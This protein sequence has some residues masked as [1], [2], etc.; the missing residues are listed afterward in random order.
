MTSLR[1]R[2]EPSAGSASLAGLG[3]GVV[4][5]GCCVGPAVAV[6][7]G[8]TSAT[9]AIDVARNLYAEWGWAFKLAGTGF[10]AAAIGVA[11]KRSLRC[12]TKPRLLRFTAILVTTASVSYGFLYIATTSLG[13]RASASTIAPI[14]VR[15]STVEA[16]LASAVMQVRR[17][18][19]DVTID[20][21]GASS[22]T[23]RFR[24]AFQIPDV[25]PSS[26]EYNEE[27]SRRIGDS[28]EATLLLLQTIATQ[29]PSIVQ[30]SASDDLMWVPTWSREQVLDSHDPH[31]YRDFDTYTRF[32]MSADALSG[33]SQLQTDRSL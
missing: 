17:R 15:G 27:V 31:E 12:S 33:Y 20:I 28:R 13:D 19:R 32:V 18:Y 9:V 10:A 3:A 16:E 14:T 11:R 29:V 22:S 6:L 26:E 7:F 24:I 30:L 1:T 2:A 21:E 25:D 23:V 5:L 4:A 8:L